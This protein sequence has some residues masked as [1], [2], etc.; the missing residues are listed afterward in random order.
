MPANNSGTNSLAGFSLIHVECL[1][2]QRIT[3]FQTCFKLLVS[4]VIYHGRQG[5]G[6]NNPDYAKS[7]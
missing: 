6:R 1:R 4:G 2:N 3:S 5:H 7:Y